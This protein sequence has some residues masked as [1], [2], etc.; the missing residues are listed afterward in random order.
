DAE[1][2]EASRSNTAG[3]ELMT[4]AKAMGTAETHREALGDAWTVAVRSLLLLMA[5]FTPH[6]AEGLW[7]RSGFEGSVHLQTWPAH[8]EAA[9]MAET[10][11]M[12]VQVNG[13]VRGQG[14]VPVDA[15]DAA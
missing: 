4:L 8:D 14:E 11:R 5:P 13:Q 12:A 10:A 9:L 2:H 1:D 15:R 7:E 3:A 6:V